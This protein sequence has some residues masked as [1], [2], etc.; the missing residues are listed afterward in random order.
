MPRGLQVSSRGPGGPDVLPGT[1][2]EVPVTSVREGS[3]FRSKG[4][5]TPPP[6]PRRE[7]APALGGKDRGGPSWTPSKD[8]ITGGR[9]GNALLARE[10]NRIG[11][12]EGGA[13]S[14]LLQAEESGLSHDACRGP[15]RGGR[16]EPRHGGPE[17]WPRLCS[18]PSSCSLP[19]PT[20]GPVPAPSL[21]QT[22]VLVGALQADER[23]S[24][25]ATSVQGRG[26]GD[27]REGVDK[28]WATTGVDAGGPSPPPSP[29]KATEAV[30][31]A[32][33]SP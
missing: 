18:G 22:R 26:P 33:V 2:D 31:G 19:L 4:A 5:E 30:R 14:R 15:G 25:V 8:S 9:H 28:R 16:G 32:R 10:R 24:H 13:E 12:W 1:R 17:R 29:P 21:T 23:R 11:S 3:S 6:P 27:P 20:L 7:L